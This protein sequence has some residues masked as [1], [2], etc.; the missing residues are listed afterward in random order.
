VDPKA[1]PWLSVQ[2]IHRSGAVLLWDA[3]ELGDEL[4]EIMRVHFPDAETQS[5]IVLMYP[6]LPKVRPGRIGLAFQ[7]P[8]R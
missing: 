6:Q 7:P 5:P 4:P 3:D 8:I 1:A 2:E